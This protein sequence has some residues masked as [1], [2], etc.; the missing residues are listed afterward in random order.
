MT[1]CD[2]GIFKSPSQQGDKMVTLRGLTCQGI[3]GLVFYVFWCFCVVFLLFQ[4]VFGCFWVFLNVFG[5][6]SVFWVLLSPLGT[7]RYFG[8]FGV[9]LGTSALSRQNS[10]CLRS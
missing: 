5:C 7:F 10:I 1:I 6:V 9:L 4:G 2:K 8:N 3:L